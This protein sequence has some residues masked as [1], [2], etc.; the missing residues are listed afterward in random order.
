MNEF[1]GI[2]VGAIAFPVAIMLHV[3]GASSVLFLCGLIER[4]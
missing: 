4:K 1:A 2:L 3:I